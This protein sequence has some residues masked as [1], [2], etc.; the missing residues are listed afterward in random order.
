MNE[1]IETAEIVPNQALATRPEAGAVGAALPASEIKPPITAAQAKVDAVAALTMTAYE[2]AA[3][4]DLTPEEAKALQADFPDEAFQPGAA[5]KE[6]LIYVEH[7]YLR[8]RFNS[9]FGMGK[10]AIVPRNR[11]SEPFKTQKGD[12]GS[13]VYV[14]AMLVVR[15]CFVGEAVGA[16]EY[17]PKNASQN[18]GD[19]V[20]GAKTAAFRRCAKEFGVGLQAWKKDFCE[21]WWQR[22]REKANFRTPRAQAPPAPVPT[23]APTPVPPFPTVESRKKMIDAL[24]ANPGEPNRDIVTDYFLKLENPSQL[25]PGEPLEKLPLRF[26]PA[27]TGQMKALAQKLAEFGNGERASAAF[28]PHA[29]PVDDA[30]KTPAQVLP[31]VAPGAAPGSE[32]FWSIIVTMPRKGMK[33][34]EYLKSPDTIKSLFD[35]RHGNDEEAQTARQRLWG[36]C[37]H[38]EA[39][40][41]VGHDG[42]ERPAS[43]ADLKFKEA[44]E[45]FKVWFAANHPDEK[46]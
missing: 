14:E 2:R 37:E 45:A 3:T 21:S 11:W 44:I 32:W 28:P 39:K 7:A 22:R 16:M 5:G 35:L 34:A 24:K 8:D 40:P 9:V 23:P 20:E 25:M 36:L 42:K 17:Y 1:T 15:G 38:F 41:W 18:Y 13:R 33:R 6:H 30:T 29:M 46:L 4:L 10:W 43:S 26:V 19:A 31:K 27:T 12:E